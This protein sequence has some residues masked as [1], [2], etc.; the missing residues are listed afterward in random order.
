METINFEKINENE[1]KVLKNKIQIH[2]H[3]TESN[4]A[5]NILDNWIEN[6]K[7]FEKEH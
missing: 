4:L 7:Y 5:K 3:Y 2:F 6:S 1:M